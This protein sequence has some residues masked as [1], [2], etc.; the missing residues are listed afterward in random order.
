MTL[1]DKIS[2]CYCGECGREIGTELS[3][4]NVKEFI[5]ELKEQVQSE[6]IPIEKHVSY[7]QGRLDALG[8]FNS[9]INELVGEKLI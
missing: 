1:S 5:K 7:F 4:K 3:I 6:N 2:G 9:A 8:I